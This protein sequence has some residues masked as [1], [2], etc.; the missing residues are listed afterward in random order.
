MLKNAE[1]ILEIYMHSE[2]DHDDIIEA[3]KAYGRLC[4]NEALRVASEE[5]M[6]SVGESCLVDKQSIL[7]LNSHPDL[8]I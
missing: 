6:T 2:S 3:M 8:A 4:V 1:E 7:A 5:A